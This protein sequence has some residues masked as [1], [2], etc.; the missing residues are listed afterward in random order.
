[1]KR[2]NF[3]TV[4]YCIVVTMILLFHSLNSYSQANWFKAG[5]ALAKYTMGGDSIVQHNQENVMTINSIDSAIQV[6]G[7]FMQVSKPD[8]YLGKRVRMTGYMKSKN[9]T[10][11]AGFWLRVDQ[12]GSQQ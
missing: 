5:S 12:A 3:K 9:V 10:T 7:T 11:W 8:K 4:C 1:M 2:Q 6:F